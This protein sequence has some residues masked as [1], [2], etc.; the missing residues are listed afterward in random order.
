MNDLSVCAP[1][2]TRHSRTHLRRS[3]T[4]EPRQ[5]PNLYAVHH[6]RRQAM[7]F[8]G[9]NHFDGNR[10]RQLAA[11]GFEMAFDTTAMGRIELPEVQHAHRR[12]ATCPTQAWRR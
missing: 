4:E 11:Q 7:R 12:S 5:A 8:I 1:D 10:L 6:V 3:E 2:L 9:D